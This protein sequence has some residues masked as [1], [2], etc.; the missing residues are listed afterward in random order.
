MPRHLRLY[1]RSQHPAAV[2]MEK[3]F[4]GWNEM[5][6]SLQEEPDMVGV[7]ERELWWVSF[8]VNLGVEIDGKNQNFGRPALVLRKFNRAMVW[9]LP[10]TQQE[11]DSRFY[12][13]FLFDGNTFYVALTQIRTIST[14]RFLRKIGMMTND[15]F[16]KIKTR[17]IGFVQN[18]EDPQSGSSRRPKP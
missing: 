12:E 6:K 15:D 5:K 2:N 8:G 3:D 14:K 16:D 17:V 13:K 7:H 11:K 4:D 10:T 9:I 1:R 18:N